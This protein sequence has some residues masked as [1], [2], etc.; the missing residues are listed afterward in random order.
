[1]FG[2][3]RRFTLTARFGR[4]KKAKGEKSE[5]HRNHG[6]TIG[7]RDPATG[8]RSAKIGVTRRP[9][10]VTASCR[11]FKPPHWFRRDIT[12]EKCYKNVTLARG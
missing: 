9:S 5:H 4:E 10:P 3:T 7:T 2:K 1:L 12:S 11:Q 6:K 8:W